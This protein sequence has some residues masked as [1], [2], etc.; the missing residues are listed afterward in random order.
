[1]MRSAWDDP[2]AVS[3]DFKAGDNKANHSHLDLGSFIV[4]ALGV[5]WACDLGAD[6]YNM[7]GYFGGK[8]WTYY[9]LR[10]E[11]HNTLV[12]NSGRDVESPGPETPRPW[13]R[14]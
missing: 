3:V 4:D 6:D 7:P 14:S 1:M 11:G 2:N 12:I 9:R 13:P 5:R 8:R 10:A